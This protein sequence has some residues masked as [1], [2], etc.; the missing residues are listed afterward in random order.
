MDLKI[1]NIDCHPDNVLV[2]FQ[3]TYNTECDFDYHILQNEI[4][5]VPKVKDNIGIGE[6]CLVQD[7]PFGSWQ[8]GK[9]FEKTNETFEVVLIDQGSMVKVNST[10]IASACGELFTLPPKIVNGI[11]S[12]ILPVGKKWSPKAVNY[13]S[14][15]VGLQVKGH[16]QSFLPNQVVVLEIPTII[17][18]VVQWNLG[19]YVDYESFRLITEIL[20]KITVNSHWKHMPDLLQQKT[21]HSDPSRTLNDDL[22]IFQKLFDHLRPH[23]SIGTTE[24]VKISSAVSPNRFHL[25]IL[26]W[27]VELINLTT[28][29]SSR[30]EA[31]K[32][33]EPNA[34]LDNFGVLCAAKRQDGLWRRGIIQKIISGEQVQVWFIDIGSSETVSSSSVQKLQP[35]FLSWPMMAIPCS[36]NKNDHA[37]CVIN[38]QMG[39]FKKGLLGQIII[40]HIDKFCSEKRQ[41]YVTLYNED[42]ELSTACHLTNQRVPVFSANAYSCKAFWAE[43]KDENS[44]LPETA[45]LTDKI[46]V[47]T[48]SYKTVQMDIDSVHVAYT[49]YVLDPS[50][51]WIRTDEFQDEFSAM[52]EKI[53]ELYSSC[54]P[55]EKVVEDPQPGMLCC[56][57]YEKDGH[58][59]RAVVTEVLNLKVT[60]Y[61]LDFG[62]TE[63]VPFYNVKILL[64][65][66]S[67]LPALA[68]CC[69]LAYAYPLDDVWVNSANDCFKQIVSN[70]PLLCHV[71]AKQ[72]YKY[73]VDVRHLENSENADIVTLMVEAGYAEYWKVN[74]NASPSCLQSSS[75]IQ[76]EKCKK[77]KFVSE[78]TCLTS[79]P[80]KRNSGTANGFS[81][82]RLQESPKEKSAS[83]QNCHHAMASTPP[84]SFKQYL[85]KPGIVLDVTVSHVNSPGDFWCQQYANSNELK[86]LM[87]DLQNY[88]SSCNDAYQHGQV[89][90]VAKNCNGK[91]YRAAVINKVSEKDIDLIFV[92][93]GNIERVS[94]SDL[95]GIKPQF[96]NLEGQAFR[97]SLNSVISPLNAHLGWNADACRD[98]RSFV[99]SSDSETVKCTVHALFCVNSTELFN[100]VNL[101]NSFTNACQFMINKGY[102]SLSCGTIQFFKLQTF[103]YSNFDIKIGNEEEVYVTYIY[104][105]GAFYCQLARN[106]GAL[107]ALMKKVSEI[108]EQIKPENSTQKKSL[109]IVKYF[110]DGN[111]YRAFA[112]PVKSS[113]LFM[114]FFVDYGNSQMVNEN[115][116]LLIPEEE[117]DVL[118][119][120][121]QAIQCSLYDIKNAILTTEVKKWF[122]EN[123]IGKLLNAVVVARDSSGQLELELYNGKVHINQKIKEL[124][125]VCSQSVKPEMLVKTNMDTSAKPDVTCSMNDS[126]SKTPTSDF[127]SLDGT[128]GQQE[129]HYKTKKG[130]INSL[131]LDS[132][133]SLCKNVLQDQVM[134]DFAQ[135]SV[136]KKDSD[137]YDSFCFNQPQPSSRTY[138]NCNDLPEAFIETGSN[139]IGYVSHID[140][141]SNFYIQLAEN[142]KKIVQIAEELNEEP[143]S[144]QAFV[145]K[146][147]KRGDLVVAEFTDLAFYR[148]EI[149]DVKE[150]NSFEVQFIDY[151]NSCNVV[152]LFVLPEKYLT[153]PKLSVCAFLSGVKKLQLDGRWS[154]DAIS[155]F[156]QKVTE[157]PLHCKFLCKHETQWEVSITC[158]GH[159]IADELLQK[160]AVT[161]LQKMP[162]QE[163]ENNLPH[164]SPFVKQHTILNPYN[165]TSDEEKYDTHSKN[166]YKIQSQSLKPNQTEKVKNIYFS[167]CGRFFVTLAGCS[168]PYSLF[169]LISATLKQANNRLALKNITKGMVC[170]IKSCKMQTW[171]RAS[172]EEIFPKETKML[173][174]YLDYGAHEKVSMYNAKKLTGDILSVPK[175]AIPCRWVWAE[176][177]EESLFRK[178]FG[179]LMQKEVQI[180]FL[181]FLESCNTW[182]VEILVNGS[183]LMEYF[184]RTKRQIENKCICSEMSYNTETENTHS[185]KF[186]IPSHALQNCT[187]YYGFVTVANDP[188]DFYLQLEDSVD[189]MNR[190][191]QLM[192]ALSDDLLTLPLDSLKPGSACLLKSFEEEEWCRAQIEEIRKD[193]ILL[194]LLDYGVCK[195]IPYLETG[196]LKCIPKHL[197]GLPSITYHCALHGVIPRSG[198]CWSKVA[199][200]FFVQFVKE[201]K[202]MITFIQN[203]SCN[204]LEV[205]VHGKY[206]LSQK[207]VSIGE[208]KFSEKSLRSVDTENVSEWPKYHTQDKMNLQEVRKE[209]E[210]ECNSHIQ[211]DF[212]YSKYKIL[213]K[214]TSCDETSAVKNRSS[215]HRL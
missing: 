139:H 150:D 12:S 8:R 164:P 193:Y 93:Y 173:V 141:P 57:L 156:S 115:E 75:Q 161:E 13:F 37:E 168:A 6:Y 41:F 82:L 51:F 53:S 68:M 92:D 177:T 120:P 190:L 83:L 9:I 169:D 69:S 114:A 145:Q 215:F 189:T 84:V 134:H 205:N 55:K 58:Y 163:I 126:G 39:L 73:V 34:G 178:V 72:K 210:Q 147:F 151:G 157:V 121:M 79:G 85:F 188:S 208:A 14:S 7:K 97:C 133:E 167:D 50:N 103:V 206:N 170:L 21:L 214:Q 1:S 96:L 122:E 207:L 117:A 61:F 148:A 77:T 175:Q 42:Y 31:I 119:V 59:Y 181:H 66:F 99:K 183:F 89:A 138:A 28:M 49:E 45:N 86:Q 192:R 98:F 70:K 174:F 43:E 106:A 94:L 90:C 33:K 199:I 171:L 38:M 35:E 48:I 176:K 116:L 102:A 23:L 180:Q 213:H 52:M 212:K 123:C 60:V 109:C 144:F 91:F 29:M 124:L 202:L 44:N 158:N 104:N 56:A 63:N 16:M 46:L 184:D 191:R 198:T 179:S 154:K 3:G 17:N 142:E 74:F 81:A 20:Q 152:S 118:F 130:L 128:K 132:K 166:I 65:Q 137:C 204:R 201:N 127:I 88:Y 62:N 162:N 185:T 160:F 5:L 47:E 2:K 110:E 203:N 32:T 100:A 153:I 78:K 211:Y 194:N 125:G 25:H 165:A 80:S 105:T 26:S 149:Q 101:E 11:F 135:H 95:R 15:L 10:Q 111:F 129:S 64:P 197:A 172:V 22:P 36:L 140:S 18:N 87:E 71:L 136:H 113:S 196:N 108:G 186:C 112:H 155:F 40:A 200:N 107:E 27:E 146:D 54:G 76:N 67:V 30:H 209:D 131:R 182:K 24:K 159:F 4:Q 195:L 143:V 187:V 19:K